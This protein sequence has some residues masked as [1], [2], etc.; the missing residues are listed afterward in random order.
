MEIP[1]NHWLTSDF[2]PSAAP[3]L[4]DQVEISKTQRV[5]KQDAVSPCHLLARRSISPQKSLRF[6]YPWSL[7]TAIKT[8]V[9]L[10]TSSVL[11]PRASLPRALQALATSLG[12]LRSQAWLE[13]YPGRHRAPSP[14]AHSVQK[15][16]NPSK[17]QL[18][19]KPAAVMIYVI[20][21]SCEPLNYLCFAH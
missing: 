12:P 18:L 2:L 16:S 21:A 13:K 1:K 5:E 17:Q 3:D 8:H 11:K 20:T 9:Y 7:R 19:T 15:G 10:L 6:P 14:P 4:N